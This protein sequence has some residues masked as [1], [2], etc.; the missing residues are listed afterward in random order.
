MG[1]AIGITAMTAAEI[2]G[3]ENVCTFE[4]NPFLVDWAKDSFARNGLNI[5]VA[6]CALMPDSQHHNA[7]VEFH[8]HPNFWGSSLVKRPGIIETINVETGSFEKVIAKRNIN[9][10]LIDIEGGELDLLLNVDISAIDKIILE[11]HY[12]IVG[13]EP[14]NNLVQH[15]VDQGFFLDLS[16]TRN[17][18]VALYRL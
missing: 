11:T 12:Q 16:I 18:V 5:D 1:T 2:I 8:I 10:L 13:K 14:S 3:E 6:Q 9:C 7:T 17:G 15:L 4:L